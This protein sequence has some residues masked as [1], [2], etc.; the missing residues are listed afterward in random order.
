M[1]GEVRDAE[2]ANIAVHAA[3][4][5]HLVLTTL[6]TE[7][8]AAAVPR[9]LDLGVEGFLLKSTLRAVIAQRLVR[10]LCDRCKSKHILDRR[11]S[12]RRSPLRGAWACGRRIVHEPAGCERCG[13][14]GYRGRCGV[15]EMLELTD[16][17]Y[18][19]VGPD[20]DARAIDLA[21]R[22]AGMTTMI[23]DA[24]RQMP[25]RLDLRRRSPSRHD[26]A[27]SHAEL[28]LPGLDPQRRSGERID[29][30][31]DGRG[32]R[33][34]RSN[35]SA[36][37]R[38]KPSAAQGE[39]VGRSLTSRFCRGRAP[40]RDDFHRRSRASSARRAPASTMRSN[41]VCR[42][43]SRP[44]AAGGRQDHRGDSRRRKLRR[45]ARPIIRLCF[46]RCMS[47]SCASARPPARSP[48]CLEV[49][50]AERVRAEALRR[51]F[52]DALR[53]PAFVL[54]AATAVLLFF[55]I[56][57]LPQFAGVLRDFNAKLDPVDASSF[58]A[59]SDF[60]ARI[61]R[62]LAAVVFALLLGGGWFSAAALR[63]CAADDRRRSRMCLS[64]AGY[65]ELSS[66]LHLL[67][68]SRRP[69]RERRPAGDDAAHPRRHD[70]ID[71]AFRS[72]ERNRRSCPSRRQ[73]F[74]RACRDEGASGDG[75]PHVAA[76]RR[77]R[78]IADARANGSRN[79]TKRSF[80]AASIGSSALSVR[81][82]SSAS[83]SSS[84]A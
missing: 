5:G 62:P 56:F 70:G 61:R 55:L 11:R 4:T 12:R 22:R 71:R 26:R 68:Q 63:A 79:F 20:A 54:A 50:G 9:L 75:H 3:L 39:R 42:R 81:R 15:F 76:R 7:T 31:A 40:R 29:F 49:L 10:I 73:A 80:S 53:Y 48:T 30:G 51:R 24:D 46:R 25:R 59:L 19:L 16:E 28:P 82:R 72:L 38:S 52:A 78:S 2:T 1:V 65:L 44:P 77:L 84:A 66:H 35:I 34:A 32:S 47:R 18:D 83:A 74:R 45:R 58:L 64:S 36:S 60:C 17:V 37:F 43:G 21:A 23:E 27:L 8:A 6:H 67:P 13:G 57:V 41:S 33:R 69:S 14:I